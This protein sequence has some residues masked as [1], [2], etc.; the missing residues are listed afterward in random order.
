MIEVLIVDAL[1]V[2]R[3]GIKQII[4]TT[5]DI[6][7][8]GEAATAADAIEKLRAGRIDL[9][10]LDMIMPGMCGIEL[11]RRLRVQYP[12]LGI[13]VFTNCAEG[14]IV[15]RALRA[16]ATGYMTKD[17]DAETLVIAIRKLAKGGRFIDPK[18]VDTVVFGDYAETA[19]PHGI[20]SDREFEILQLLAT[21]VSINE[22]AKSFALSAKTISTHKMRLMGKLELKNN[23]ELVRYAMKYNLIRD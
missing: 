13:L 9:L 19:L 8:A 10:L 15:S 22:I 4:A 3:L 2:V 1:A 14:N 11:I 18:L 21:G 6:V 16:G 5:T 12:V 23:S 20:L 7:V 17:S